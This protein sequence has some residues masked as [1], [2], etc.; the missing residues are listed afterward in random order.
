MGGQVQG[1]QVGGRLGAHT[2]IC[3][4]L[5]WRPLL[6]LRLLLSLCQLLLLR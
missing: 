5:F 1:Q 6:S 4:L 3:L 2:P